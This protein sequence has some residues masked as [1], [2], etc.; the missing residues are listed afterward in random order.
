MKKRK[1]WKKEIVRKGREILVSMF[2]VS[3]RQ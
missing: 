1:E 2:Y 3:L